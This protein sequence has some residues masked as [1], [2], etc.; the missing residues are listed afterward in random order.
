MAQCQ[1]VSLHHSSVVCGGGWWRCRCGCLG[2]LVVCVG[3]TS[4]G[5]ACSTCFPLTP[6]LDGWGHLACV[7]CAMYRMRVLRRELCGALA[8]APCVV[9]PPSQSD[10]MYPPTFSTVTL[11]CSAPYARALVFADLDKDGDLDA[12]SASWNSDRIE[13]YR[14][15]TC[16]RGTYG[17]F[18]APPCLPCSPGAFGAVQGLGD[19]AGGVCSGLCPAGRWSGPGATGCTLCPAGRYGA[20][21]GSASAACSGPCVPAAGRA[22]NAGETSP[23]GSPCPAGTYGDGVGPCASCPVGRH[24][25][26]PGLSSPACSGP[27]VAAAGSVCR[28]GATS[29]TGTPCPS[30]SYADGLDACVLCP[31]GRYGGAA[32]LSAP[33]CTGPCA[34]APGRYCPSGAVSP[35]GVVCPAGTFSNTT[36]AVTCFPCAAGFAGLRRNQTSANCTGP[37]PI[38]RYSPAGA[39]ECSLCPGRACARARACVLLFAE[40]VRPPGGVCE[41]SAV[42][43][44]LCACCFPPTD[45]CAPCSFCAPSRVS[46]RVLCAQLACRP[47]VCSGHFRRCARLVHSGVQRGVRGFSGQLLPRGGSV[48]HPIALLL[49]AVQ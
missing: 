29:A 49:S 43:A 12:A 33:T 42:R 18:G 28:S 24:G 39:E 40:R 5:C 14:T 38:G 13:W 11:T 48:C 41:C 46:V 25:S 44:V 6:Q 32:G 8:G 22:C 21:Q 47:P 34:A 35:E 10:G 19:E 37:C 26:T 16:P 31:A 15:E 20:S 3:P 27:C 7:L 30:G 23:S 1:F 9:F 17:L 2:G 4:V 45:F 36:G